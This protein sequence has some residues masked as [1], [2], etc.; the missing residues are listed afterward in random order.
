L[1]D[2]RSNVKWADGRGGT[3]GVARET[4][5]ISIWGGKKEFRR[6]SIDKR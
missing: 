1:T 5:Q 4:Y 6:E 3:K 2:R